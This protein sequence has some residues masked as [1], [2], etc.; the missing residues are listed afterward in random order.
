MRGTYRVPFGRAGLVGL[1][2]ALVLLCLPGTSIAGG[3]SDTS[4]ASKAGQTLL[5]YGAGYGKAEGAPQVRSD[6]AHAAAAGLAARPAGRVVRAPDRGRCHPLPISHTRGDRRHRRPADPAGIDAGEK[7]AAPAGSWLRAAERI[8]AGAGA[9]G[10]VARPG[11]SP[12][13]G[14]RPVRAADAGGGPTPPAL[15][16]GPGQWRRHRAHQAAVGR[17]LQGAG[18]ACRQHAGRAQARHRADGHRR[19]PG[20]T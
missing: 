11:A 18:P 1:V 15:R 20:P 6:S 10:Q 3:A 17:R 16:R 9:P 4:S 13:A 2:A 12:R 19:Q 14:G 8:A 5:H 7:R